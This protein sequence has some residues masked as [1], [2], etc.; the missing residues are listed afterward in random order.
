MTNKGNGE[1]EG[2]IHREIG[3]E[4]KKWNLSQIRTVNLDSHGIIYN[5]I[6]VKRRC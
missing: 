5:A 6:M 1:V 2:G 4:R 3:M